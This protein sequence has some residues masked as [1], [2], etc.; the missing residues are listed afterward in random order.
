MR[1][2]CFFPSIFRI[3]FSRAAVKQLVNKC[4]C[5]KIDS[6][7]DRIIGEL[8]VSRVLPFLGMCAKDLKIPIVHSSALHYWRPLDYPD[9]YLKCDLVCSFIFLNV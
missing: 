1:L 5:P 4:Q 6:P 8:Y 9:E 3:I 7:D 2:F